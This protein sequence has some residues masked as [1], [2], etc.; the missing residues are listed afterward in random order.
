MPKI[1]RLLGGPDAVKEVGRRAFDG[2]R[3]KARKDAEKFADD[4]QDKVKGEAVKE[5]EK[6][7]GKQAKEI[8]NLV[9]G[10]ANTAEAL[11]KL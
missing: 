2:V 4:L 9:E 11:N 5:V 1:N 8:K 10:V 3:K 6:R 7:V